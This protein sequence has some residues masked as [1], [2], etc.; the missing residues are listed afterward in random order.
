MLQN[1]QAR[2]ADG[3]WAGSW[4]AGRIRMSGKDVW[5]GTEGWAGHEKSFELAMYKPTWLKENLLC[6]FVE[7]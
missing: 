6:E 1:S 7:L 3:L 2:E 4:R 5:V